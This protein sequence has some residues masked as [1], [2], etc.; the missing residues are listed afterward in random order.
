MNSEIEKDINVKTEYKSK[1]VYRRFVGI[2]FTV[3]G[4]LIAAVI[5]VVV[6]V[7]PFFH[8]HG[9]IEGFPYIIDDQLSQNPGLAKNTDYDAVSVGSSISVNMKVSAFKEYFDVDAVKLPYNAACSKDIYNALSMA[10]AS[11]NTVEKVFWSVDIR[12]MTKD[13]ET[14]YPLPEYLYDDNPLNDVYYIFNRDVLLNYILK[15]FLYKHNATNPDEYYCTYHLF[16]YGWDRVLYGFRS[17]EKQQG[18]DYSEELA[19]AI[20]GVNRNF[21]TYL[22]DIIED[23][24]DTEFYIYFAPRSVAYWYE[25]RQNGETEVIFEAE[26]ALIDR[27]LC[28]DNVKV[29]YFEDDQDIITDFNNYFDSV[30]FGAD[31]SDEIIKRMSAG[32]S[33]LDNEN[34]QEIIEGFCEY[35]DN[36]DYSIYIWE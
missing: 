10:F 18:I 14:A 13:T 36:Y 5:A 19:E 24:P 34:Y 16:T 31:T 7:D 3:V 21:D 20:A 12:N 8:Y 11:D 1:N 17:I 2:F 4:V 35:L 6:Y 26:K 29:F 22:K 28:Y 25:Y 15:P 9:P 30:H 32:E 23:N 33:T 27:L